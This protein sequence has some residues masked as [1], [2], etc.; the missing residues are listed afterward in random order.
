MREN[1]AQGL[2]II[3]KITY[4]IRVKLIFNLQ[5]LYLIIQFS[6]YCAVGGCSSY[7]DSVIT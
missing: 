2:N 6:V 1:K 4:L 7:E 5:N 3:P